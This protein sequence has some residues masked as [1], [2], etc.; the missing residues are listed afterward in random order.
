MCPK[1]L[2]AASTLGAGRDI[3]P[4]LKGEEYLAGFRVM[5]FPVLCSDT[6]KVPDTMLF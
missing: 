6:C 3:I 1:R 4:Y 5:R 2:I